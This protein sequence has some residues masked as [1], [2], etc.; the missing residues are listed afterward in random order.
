VLLQEGRVLA[1]GRIGEMLTRSDLPLFHG[2]EAEA[3]LEATVVG[4]D[5]IYDL[6]H[7]EFPGGRFNVTRTDL[8]VG[9]VVRLRILARDVSLTLERQTDTSILNIFPVTVEELAEEG[10]AQVMVRLSAGSTPILSRITR[11]SADALE[12][13]PGKQVYAQIKTVALLA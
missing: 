11:R 13:A 6:T 1:S 7:L 5:E 2:D 12:L 10:P 3:I 9:Q 4:H 8:E